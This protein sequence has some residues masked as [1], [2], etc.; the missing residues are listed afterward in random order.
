MDLQ[1]HVGVDLQKHVGVELAA[2]RLAA[3]HHVFHNV[4][5]A[6]L[7]NVVEQ[8]PHRILCLKYVGFCV[9][10]NRPIEV[11]IGHM[12]TV[13]RWAAPPPSSRPC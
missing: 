5:S 9:A 10:L 2:H 1:K 13:S 12:Q 6:A 4:S 3:D 8:L 11:G 7:G